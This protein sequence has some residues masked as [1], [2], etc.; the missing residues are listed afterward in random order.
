M[1][2]NANNSYTDFVLNLCTVL[3]PY[4]SVWVKKEWKKESK[5]QCFTKFKYL[6]WQVHLRVH[7]CDG[8]GAGGGRNWF[9]PS[10]PP[11]GCCTDNIIEND[12]LTQQIFI[13][14]SFSKVPENKY[15]LF[16][17]LIVC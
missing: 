7:V 17:L 14:N 1:Y 9:T 8:G 12:Y 3:H 4:F 2:Y 13:I 15:T 10:F 11:N 5:C 6:A 16:K